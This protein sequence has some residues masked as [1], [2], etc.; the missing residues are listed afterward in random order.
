MQQWHKN[1]SKKF[2]HVCSKRKTDPRRSTNFFNLN[3]K[4]TD[5][6]IK[7]N[8]IHD[9]CIIIVWVRNC[10]HVQ[11]LST[12]TR[13]WK[14]KK[15]KILKVWFFLNESMKLFDAERNLFHATH[16]ESVHWLKSFWR[17]SI[18]IGPRFISR[19]IAWDLF[20]IMKRIWI[21]ITNI[22]FFLWQSVR[23][24]YVSE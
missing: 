13:K 2:K 4:V 17:S 21:H 18:N 24:S 7:F 3:C 5:R 22:F 9:F 15:N 23:D 10:E 19:Y 16:F 20:C 14:T 6:I 11:H 12:L 8:L 1:G